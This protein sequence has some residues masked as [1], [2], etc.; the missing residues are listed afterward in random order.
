MRILLDAG[1][2]LMLVGAGLG[3]SAAPAAACPYGTVPSSFEGVCVSGQSGA[4]MVPPMTPSSNGAVIG[5]GV[6]Q[7]PTVNGIPC[8]PEKIGTCIGLIQSQ[9]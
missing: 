1:A 3:V 2:C 6:N 8:T 7:L 4:Q 9:G 5:G